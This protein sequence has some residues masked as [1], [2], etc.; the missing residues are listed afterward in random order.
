[1]IFYSF[2]KFYLNSVYI[3]IG[4]SRK[5]FSI[6][7]NILPSRLVTFGKITQT[8]LFLHVA[9]K[10][11]IKHADVFKIFRKWV[12]YFF[13]VLNTVAYHLDRV[14]FTATG[15]G[16][17]RLEVIFWLKKR[18]RLIQCHCRVTRDKWRVT[19]T[20]YV[21]VPA[22][23]DGGFTTSSLRIYRA[24]TAQNG[25]SIRIDRCVGYRIYVV[26]A[27]WQLYR[28]KKKKKTIKWKKEKS[29]SPTRAFFPYRPS[30]VCTHAHNW[31]YVYT[32]R[33]V[34]PITIKRVLFNIM[35]FRSIR[36]ILP[37][38]RTP[39]PPLPPP[40][41]SNPWR[42]IVSILLLWFILYAYGRVCA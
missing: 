35:A 29:I 3:H 10:P 27:Q 25:D 34:Q 15:C 39:S 1:M 31:V 32:D 38:R 20:T 19:H 11:E 6:Q 2:V 41:P 5:W 18:D 37:N 42:T 12:K 14:R 30:D 8:L 7:N 16:G 22:E 28:N 4:I 9:A 24:V 33:V 13:Y 40:P 36:S 26:A 17:T 23:Q 21:H